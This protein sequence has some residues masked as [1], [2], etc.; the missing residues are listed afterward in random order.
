MYF[1]FREYTNCE[2]IELIQPPVNLVKVVH[3]LCEFPCLHQIGLNIWTSMDTQ[4]N[5]ISR[6]CLT[7]DGIH[8]LLNHAHQI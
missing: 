7:S 6:S 5:A 2:P 3:T 1:A 8:L 4:A